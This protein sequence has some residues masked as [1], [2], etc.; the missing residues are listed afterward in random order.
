MP[1]PT[2][3]T[4]QPIDYAGSPKPAVGE[5]PDR[6]ANGD[7][8]EA[9]GGRNRGP[10]VA[11]ILVLLVA[12]TVAM[13]GFIWYRWSG[14]REPTTAIIMHG[15]ASLDGTQITVSGERAVTA[16]LD[17][18]NNYHVPILVDPGKYDVT[19]ELRGRTIVHATAEVKRFLGVEFDLST[20]VKDAV[21][22]G[23]LTLDPPPPASSTQPA[24]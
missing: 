20:I 19:A 10:L 23:T 8:N 14:V 21:A 12:S 24:R 15:D 1:T 18:S 13:V 2:K 4:P 3:E 17:A 7:G 5:T 9:N 22:R 11:A 6:D 16:T